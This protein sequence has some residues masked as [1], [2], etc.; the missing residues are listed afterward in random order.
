MAQSKRRYTGQTTAIGIL[1]A[2]V[3]FAAGCAHLVPSNPYSGYRPEKKATGKRVPERF[4][5]VML[6]HSAFEKLSGRS[7]QPNAAQAAAIDIAA[8][9]AKP[10]VE[11]AAK[12]IKKSIDSA[13]A[14]HLSGYEAT[15]V[16]RDFY[17]DVIGP[18]LSYQGFLVVRELDFS[19]RPNELQHDVH[20]H[21]YCTEMRALLGAKDDVSV[22]DDEFHWCPV[23][24]LLFEID[25]SLLDAG[26]FRVRPVD[27]SLSLFRTRAKIVDPTWW[28]PWTWWTNDR[29]DA[30]YAPTKGDKDYLDAL[31]VKVTIGTAYTTLA[32]EARTITQAPLFEHTWGFKRVC[33]DEERQRLRVVEDEDGGAADHGSKQTSS[34]RCERAG[35]ATQGATRDIPWSEPIPLVPRGMIIEKASG[36]NQV[37]YGP[38]IYQMKVRVTEMDTMADRLGDLADLVGDGGDDAGKFV[39]DKLKDLGK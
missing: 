30:W 16:G 11:L 22:S 12:E 9:I 39:K 36:Q 1:L 33:L 17:A 25:E 29:D 27:R 4:S 38:G 34:T 14:L 28:V 24:S 5:I 31:D 8:E 3:C 18:Q 19:V 37:K 10:L 21:S 23:M 6:T 35:A 13:A 2:G 7:Q 32:D 26:A 15:R 20:L